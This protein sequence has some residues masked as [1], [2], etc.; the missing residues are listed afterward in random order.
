MHLTFGSVLAF[1]AILLVAGG[2]GGQS[3]H[4]PTTAEARRA[5]LRFGNAVL[6]SPDRGSAIQAAQ[7]FGGTPIAE[8]VHDWYP[9]LKAREQLHVVSVSDGCSAASSASL[10]PPAGKG[11]CF[12]LRLLGSVV[13]DR[14]PAYR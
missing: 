1:L 14:R 6:E 13:P 10:G 8:E 3:G 5:A 12:S 9:D 11:P 2:C 4:P 7:R